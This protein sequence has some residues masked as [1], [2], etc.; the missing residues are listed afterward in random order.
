MRLRA[1]VAVA[2][3]TALAAS[4][5][6]ARAYN[7]V[8]NGDFD[9]SLAGWYLAPSWV[10]DSWSPLDAGGS[11]ASGSA[12]LENVNDDGI[13]A[14]GIGQCVP[15]TAGESDRVRG[16]IYVPGGQAADGLAGIHFQW[17]ESADCTG[18]AIGGALGTDGEA[19]GFDE[20]YHWHSDLVPAPVGAQALVLELTSRKSDAAGTFVT[21]WDDLFVPEPAAALL[22]AAALG[23]LAALGRMRH[24][25]P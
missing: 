4:S 14:G 11:P 15:V 22:Q 9:A 17:N 18:D 25:R 5:G 19:A 1:G 6:T 2:I 13:Q 24:G 10:Q 21:H 16:S 8:E 12:R 23:A 20:W 7:L 3:G